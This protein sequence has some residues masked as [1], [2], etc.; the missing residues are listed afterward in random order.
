MPT[1]YVYCT[2]NVDDE[3]ALSLTDLGPN[4]TGAT[5]LTTGIPAVASN[6]SIA[7]IPRNLNMMHL[8]F[9]DISLFID[10]SYITSLQVLLHGHTPGSMIW[11][12]WRKADQ[13]VGYWLTDHTSHDTTI[14][15]RGNTYQFYVT[16]QKSS[17]YDDIG[18]KL[19]K[20]S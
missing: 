14:T 6:V 18:I 7:E 1:T 3:V 13:A 11:W 17:G 20:S 8:Y 12:R 10:G 9:L 4:K 19:I 5:L 16:G 2:S 15:A